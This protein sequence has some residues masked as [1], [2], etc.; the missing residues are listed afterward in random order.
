[1]SAESLLIYFVT[2]LEDESFLKTMAEQLEEVLKRE[3][4]MGEEEE[5][6]DMEAETNTTSDPELSF[7]TQFFIGSTCVFCLVAIPAA[8]ASHL[9]GPGEWL[10]VFCA[11]GMGIGALLFSLTL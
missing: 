5:R 2:S 7:W 1:M 4:E 3:G 10:N 6:E 8:V 9:A 11:V